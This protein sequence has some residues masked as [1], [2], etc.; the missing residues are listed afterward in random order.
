VLTEAPL[1][2]CASSLAGCA[3]DESSTKVSAAFG[4]AEHGPIIGEHVVSRGQHIWRFI[5]DTNRVAH[6]AVGVADAAAGKPVTTNSGPCAYGLH[7]GRGRIF[8]SSTGHKLGSG[9]ALH[10]QTPR[11]VKELSGQGPVSVIVLVDMDHGRL[12]FAVGSNT[13]IDSGLRLPDAVRPWVWLGGPGVGSVS[14]VECTYTVAQ[15]PAPAPTPVVVDLA[16]VEELDITSATTSKQTRSGPTGTGLPDEADRTLALALPERDQIV[17]G[18]DIQTPATPARSES[19][20]QSSGQAEP[21]PWTHRAG[22]W[23][24]GLQQAMG[25]LSPKSEQQA[26]ENAAVSA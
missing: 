19:G 2:F 18:D 16:T 4:T 5:V 12:S 7:L 8:K 15:P 6:L 1:R 9:K 21:I 11:Q 23:L 13:A 26:T 20:S 25:L 3:V 22:D 24:A 10:A 14:I 17:A